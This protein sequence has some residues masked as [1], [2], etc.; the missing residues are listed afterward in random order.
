LWGCGFHV[1]KEPE[2]AMFADD[3]IIQLFLPTDDIQAEKENEWV[4]K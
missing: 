1:Y 2:E 3:Q 4:D